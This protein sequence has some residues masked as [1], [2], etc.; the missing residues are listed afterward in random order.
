MRLIDDG[1]Y[2][3]TIIENYIAQRILNILYLNNVSIARETDEK[4]EYSFA[5]RKGNPDLFNIFSKGLDVLQQTGEF[6]KIQSRWVEQRFLISQGAR[7]TIMVSILVGIG[8]SLFVLA[9]FFIWTVTLQ[10]EVGVRTAALS[11]EIE[12][13]KRTEQQL[14]ANQAQLIQADK[15]AA[16]GTLASGI[17]H[18]INNPNG[19]ILLNI[20]F[21][22]RLSSEILQKS[23]TP[24]RSM[25][26]SRLPAFPTP[27]CAS[28]CPTCSRTWRV[29]RPGS[30]P[31][32]RN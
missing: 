15:L 12:V 24:R 23:Q 19:L 28:A 27:C 7:N 5:V 2:D 16:I 21:L 3:Y 22:K 10:E 9:L 6:N 32:C 1:T 11:S 14:L 20:S 25:K 30:G 8:I 13:R 4:V 18:E 31:L 26:R 17:A 29:P